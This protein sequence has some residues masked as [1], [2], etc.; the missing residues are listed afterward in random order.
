LYDQ[1]G[2]AR[3]GILFN[4]TSANGLYTWDANGTQ[5]VNLG[6]SLNSD[7]ELQL[8]NAAGN[9]GFTALVD[10]TSTFNGLALWDPNLVG[11]VKLEEIGEVLTF[12]ADGTETGDLP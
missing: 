10:P 7:S 11:R 12:A 3:D 9:R 2:L 4:D 5:R 1:T 6:Q 8:H